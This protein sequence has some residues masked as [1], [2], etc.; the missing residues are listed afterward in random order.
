MIGFFGVGAQLGDLDSDQRALRE[1]DHRLFDPPHVRAR[2]F[3][4]SATAM[5]DGKIVGTRIE[6]SFRK[7]RSMGWP[8]QDGLKCRVP[9]REHPTRILNED[10]A[11]RRLAHSVPLQ[12]RREVP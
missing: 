4:T 11:D 9:G 1:M 12:A 10:V 2:G 5:G 8:L 3:S 7:G 6:R